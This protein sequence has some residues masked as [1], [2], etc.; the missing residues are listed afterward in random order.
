[1]FD[2]FSLVCGMLPT[3]ESVCLTITQ[4]STL[5]VY[6][7]TSSHVG[8][9]AAANHS[10]NPRPSNVTSDWSLLGTATFDWS[11][12]RRGALGAH[13]QNIQQ[14]M[15]ELA[16]LLRVLSPKCMLLARLRLETEV[17]LV[18]SYMND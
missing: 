3:E 4:E 13:I 11:R 6:L 5:N 12:F 17:A 16:S 18:N 10:L 1:M 14:V 2:T 8:S 9:E 15:V 7:Q